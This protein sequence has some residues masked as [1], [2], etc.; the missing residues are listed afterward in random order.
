VSVSSAARHQRASGGSASEPGVALTKLALPR[1]TL[2]CTFGAKTEFPGQGWPPRD[3]TERST[4]HY[5]TL[6][7][8]FSTVSAETDPH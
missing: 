2:Q 1:A 5:E 3:L 8:K 6:T 4:E 7:D